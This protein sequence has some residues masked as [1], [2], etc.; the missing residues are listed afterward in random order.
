[1]DTPKK[2]DV[3]TLTTLVVWLITAAIIA[4]RY[5]K[6]L[7]LIVLTLFGFGYFG[8]YVGFYFLIGRQRNKEVSYG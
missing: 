7:G 1:M 2:Q 6:P 4:L 5:E 3:W 8:I